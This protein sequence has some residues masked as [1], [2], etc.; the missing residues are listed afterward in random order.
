MNT[1][2]DK[3]DSQSPALYLFS[4]FTSI[5]T[6]REIFFDALLIFAHLEGVVE[7]PLQGE[8]WEHHENGF[9]SVLGRDNGV[10]VVACS[11]A[12]RAKK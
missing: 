5:L 12:N 11:E 3:W 10:E 7:E 9:Y 2:T 6:I 8:P 1:A 4:V